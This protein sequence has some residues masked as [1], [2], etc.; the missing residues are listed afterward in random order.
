MPCVPGRAQNLPG[1]AECLECNPGLFSE[2]MLGIKC[3]ECNI[4]KTS[5]SGAAACIA[6]DLGTFAAVKGK[7]FFLVYDQFT[8]MHFVPLLTILCIFFL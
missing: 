8:H 2:T 7:F 3:D 6:C 5:D 1:Q 4:G